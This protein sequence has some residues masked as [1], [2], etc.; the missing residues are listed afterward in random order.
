MFSGVGAEL[1][2]VPE[3]EELWITELYNLPFG[4]QTYG[5]HKDIHSLWL[6]NPISTN[7]YPQNLI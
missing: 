7:S 3:N 4:M 2:E 5:R 1:G 6:D